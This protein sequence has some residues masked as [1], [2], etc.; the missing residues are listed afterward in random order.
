MRLI[1]CS[2]LCRGGTLEPVQSVTDSLTEPQSEMEGI[3][4]AYKLVGQGCAAIH[5]MFTI[6]NSLN[7]HAFSPHSHPSPLRNAA[8]VFFIHTRPFN[9]YCNPNAILN[10][11]IYCHPC[12]MCCSRRPL[13]HTLR[14]G[15]NEDQ[16]QSVIAGSCLC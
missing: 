10:I 14:V 13:V 6:A 1:P 2:R 5:A 9:Q 3:S 4:A 7:A 15:A 16:L 11:T 12:A 8:P